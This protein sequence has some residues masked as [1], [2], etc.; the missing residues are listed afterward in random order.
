MKKASTTILPAKQAKACR[1]L[2]ITAAFH[3]LYA[4]SLL[5]HHINHLVHEPAAGIQ[6]RRFHHDAHHG[7]GAG[8]AQ[9][10]TSIS[11]QAF[12]HF[13]H[14]CLDRLIVLGLLF[15]LDPHVLKYLRID[16]N[17]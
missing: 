3:P 15:I 11:P 10:D 4:V 7:L 2:M 13:C 6:V 1:I 16:I 5:L 17:L 9:E 12:S 8:L 14:L